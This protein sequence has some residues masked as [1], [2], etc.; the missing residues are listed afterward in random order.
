MRK[1]SQADSPTAIGIR[2]YL[3]WRPIQDPERGVP[4]RNIMHPRNIV[5]KSDTAWEI[6]RI[7]QRFSHS[8]REIQVHSW[9][10]KIRYNPWAHIS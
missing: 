6:L 1:I 9:S 5:I 3:R 8:L 4:C 2:K 10:I 7:V